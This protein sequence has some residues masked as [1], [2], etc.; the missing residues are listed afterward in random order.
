MKRKLT[1][2]LEKRKEM[3]VA[4]L[5]AN[6]GFEGQ[7]GANARKASIQQLEEHYDEAVARIW[8]PTG[9]LPE[10]EEE[11]IDEKNPFFAAAKKG[12]KEIEKPRNDEGSVREALMEGYSIDQ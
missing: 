10:E 3:M 1:E 12:M 8:S 6:S 11:E 4:A 9:R 7:E 2:T 5:W